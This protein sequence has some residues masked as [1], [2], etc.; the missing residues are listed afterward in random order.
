MSAALAD[1]KTFCSSAGTGFAHFAKETP[2]RKP[3]IILEADPPEHI[4][5][6]K[7]RGPP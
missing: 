1:P 3:S 4:R 5:T 2:W 6:R 7:V